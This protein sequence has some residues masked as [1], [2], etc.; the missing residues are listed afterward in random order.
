MWLTSL[1]L[2]ALF[3]VFTSPCSFFSLRRDFVYPVQQV[4]LPSLPCPEAKKSQVTKK[5]QIVSV[6]NVEQSTS[7]SPETSEISRFP[8]V[9]PE[10]SLAPTVSPEATPPMATL[11][12]APQAAVGDGN[13]QV[14]SLM[15]EPCH[16]D[17]SGTFAAQ[18]FG[19]I[20][21]RNS[22]GSREQELGTH[23][24][25]GKGSDMKG[26]FDW[27]TGLTKFFNQY[28]ELQTIADIPSGDMGWQMAVRHLNTA[29]LYFGGDIA[30][31]VAEDNAR[32]YKSHGNKILQ[33]WD[34]HS[35][36]APKWHTT[37]DLTPYSFDVI[38]IR[39]ALQH[40]SIDKV[41]EILRKVILESGA[42]WFITSSYP[43]SDT[44]RSDS[45]ACSTD[46]NLFCSKGAMPRGDGGWYPIALDCAP[47]RFP[48]PYSKTKSHST[49]PIENDFMYVYKIDDAL[50]E[51][52]RTM[53]PCPVLGDRKSVV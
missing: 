34:L 19:D 44:L 47:F 49:F 43:G 40:I 53:K 4:T 31:S 29:K 7:T 24:K 51:A 25:S 2:V 46:E 36:G 37:C 20:Y 12:A 52:V 22:W 45:G 17:S 6:A 42:K 18:T 27:I 23:T 50:K 33:H 10:T 5:Q 26:A 14:C 15:V 41:Q 38:M 21:V 16:V 28:P 32:R 9:P 3:F 11:P 39:D 48:A 8:K 13:S 1:N 35:C 30:K